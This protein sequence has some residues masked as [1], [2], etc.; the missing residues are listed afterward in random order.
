M[1]IRKLFYVTIL[2]SLIRLGINLLFPYIIIHYNLS[3]F[4][5]GLIS[6]ITNILFWVCMLWLVFKV[7]MTS[8]LK[9]YIKLL[10]PLI[11]LILLISRANDIQKLIWEN[12]KPNFESKIIPDMIKDDFNNTQSN[13]VYISLNY[14]EERIVPETYNP[15]GK[16]YSIFIYNETANSIRANEKI[17]IKP[18]ESYLF[19]IP[20]TMG[21]AL[22]NGIQFFFGETEGLEVID[23]NIQVSGLGDDWRHKLN[24]PKSTDWAFSILKAGKGDSI[25][26][27]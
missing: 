11:I 23:N 24:V 5:L 18:N 21:I 9:K 17:T 13:K 1:T 15:T 8:E 3:P 16:V 20:D 27:E 6:G 22:D 10:I 7:F 19:K 25:P 14:D 12:P 26:K 2:F 4:N